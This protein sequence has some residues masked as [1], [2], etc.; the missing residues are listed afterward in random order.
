MTLELPSPCQL[1]DGNGRRP[2]LTFDGRTVWYTRC[3]ACEGRDFSTPLLAWADRVGFAWP[4][5]SSVETRG[6]VLN[7]G[8]AFP[9]DAISGSL[10]QPT[11][12]GSTGPREAVA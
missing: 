9:A 1:C 8:L 12:S 11:S 10:G 6:V 2:E 5:A 4:A 7:G 3:P